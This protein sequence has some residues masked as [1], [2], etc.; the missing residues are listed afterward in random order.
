MWHKLRCSV[1]SHKG[2]GI[3][4]HGGVEKTGS[5]GNRLKIREPAK[6]HNFQGGGG[7]GV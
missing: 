2:S 5:P 6:K 7:G 4:S 1:S 3:T